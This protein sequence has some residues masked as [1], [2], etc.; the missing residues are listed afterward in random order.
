MQTEL[1]LDTEFL[2]EFG[3]TLSEIEQ[4][5]GRTT[6]EHISSVNNDGSVA[7]Y[8]YYF[9]RGN[10][11]GYYF[12]L[13]YSN[14]VMYEYEIAVANSPDSVTRLADVDNSGE[15]IIF[16]GFTG[17]AA[18][19]F[20]GLESAINSE[21]LRTISGVEVSVDENG[22]DTFWMG[23]NSI[24]D[25]VTEFWHNGHYLISIRHENERVIEPNSWLSITY[26]PQGVW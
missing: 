9:E 8:T 24:G 18:D 23:H 19:V 26:Y 13:L 16:K 1:R 22:N 17:V 12:C 10:D 6:N 4:R 21:D 20:L 7:G 11:R 15:R 25:Y 14:F 2:A 3:M 5:R